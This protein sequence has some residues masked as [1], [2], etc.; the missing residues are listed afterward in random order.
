[1]RLGVISINRFA[2]PDKRPLNVRPEL[3]FFFI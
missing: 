3:I 2:H 1:M